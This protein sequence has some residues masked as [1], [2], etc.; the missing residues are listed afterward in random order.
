MN[1]ISAVGIMKGIEPDRVYAHLSEDKEIVEMKKGYEFIADLGRWIDEHS[2][3][4]GQ[5]YVFHPLG[6]CPIHKLLETHR[7]PFNGHTIYHTDG[8]AEIKLDDHCYYDVKVN[9]RHVY[10]TSFQRDAE[11]IAV[12][13]NEVL[14]K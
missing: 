11:R 2:S 1:R 14:T 6:P 9:G 4:V 7:D 8:A 12:Q 10:A 13:I 3:G 5:T